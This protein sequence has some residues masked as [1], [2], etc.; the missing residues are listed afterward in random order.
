[1]EAFSRLPDEKLIVVGSYEQAGHF[2]RHA[3]YIRKIKPANVGILSW[4]G[5]SQLLELYANCKG[6]ITTSK[7]EDFG[8]TVVEAMASGKP[9]IALNEGGYKETVIDGV[10]G[11]LI[12]DINPGKLIQ[13]VKEIG[14][15][16]GRYK[17]ACLKQAAKFDTK[18]FIAKIKEQMLRSF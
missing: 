17:D 1:M 18:V 6:F 12:D 8:M 2:R 4:V 15:D 7:D 13:A 9:V 10:T 14:K 3:D 5:R 16:S 11:R